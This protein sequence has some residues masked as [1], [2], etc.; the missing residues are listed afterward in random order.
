MD[1]AT[2]RSASKAFV[3]LDGRPLGHR[4]DVLCQMRVEPAFSPPLEDVEE[5]G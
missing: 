2:E 4:R 3:A 1:Y 5:E